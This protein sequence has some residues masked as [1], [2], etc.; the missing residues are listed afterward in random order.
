MAAYK[1][2][3]F[4]GIS[5]LSDPPSIDSIIRQMLMDVAANSK[6]DQRYIFG[7]LLDD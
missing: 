1:I 3:Q 7:K 6:E 5:A 4:G 2:P